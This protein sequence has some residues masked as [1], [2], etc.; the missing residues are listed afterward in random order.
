MPLNDSVQKTLNWIFN[1]E[2]DIV[3]DAI[4]YLVI[5]ASGMIFSLSIRFSLPHSTAMGK[6]ERLFD[7]LNR[8]CYQHDPG[9]LLI[10]GIGPFPRLEVAVRP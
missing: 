8:A 9:S 7:K 3:K 10:L 4:T 2:A 5:I 6:A 1:L